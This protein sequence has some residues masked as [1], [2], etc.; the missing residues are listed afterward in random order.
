MRILFALLMLTLSFQ[1]QAQWQFIGNTGSIDTTSNNTKYMDLDYYTTTGSF[2]IA[3]GSQSCSICN[4]GVA[5]GSIT[6]KTAAQVLYPGQ[7]VQMEA[8]YPED[9][10]LV[11]GLRIPRITGSAAGTTFTI[12]VQY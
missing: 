6:I 7:C 1:A 12:I 2:S 5:N 8:T 9:R 10:R 3:K 4:V 11:V